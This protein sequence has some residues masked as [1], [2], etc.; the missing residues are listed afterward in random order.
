MSLRLRPLPTN[1]EFTCVAPS[2]DSS[3]RPRRLWLR[4]RRLFR[5]LQLQRRIMCERGWGVTRTTCS[6]RLHRSRTKR[7]RSEYA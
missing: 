4:H 1:T 6:L 7:R 2:R 5:R 3:I